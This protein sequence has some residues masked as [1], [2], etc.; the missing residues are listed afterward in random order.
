MISCLSSPLIP[1]VS[2][3]VLI[4]MCFCSSVRNHILHQSLMVFFPWAV[5]FSNSVVEVHT[6]QEKLYF[7]Y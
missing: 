6:F 3:N 1:D 5:S 7:L 4:Y 2:F